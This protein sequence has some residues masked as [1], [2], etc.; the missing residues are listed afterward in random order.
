[1]KYPLREGK[2]IQIQVYKISN[3]LQKLKLYGMKICIYVF[4]LLSFLFSSCKG[5]QAPTPQ[6]EPLAIEAFR[7][8]SKSTPETDQSYTNDIW[9]VSIYRNKNYHLRIPFPVGWEYDNGMSS[10]TLA[11]AIDRQH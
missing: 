9:H 3:R 1:M 8:F 10:N 6:E 7:R 11:R 4:L 5:P 2:T